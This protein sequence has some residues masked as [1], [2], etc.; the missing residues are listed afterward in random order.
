MLRDG[1]DWMQKEIAGWG[2]KGILGSASTVS[3]MYDNK[4]GRGGHITR[5][6]LLWIVAKAMFQNDNPPV[7]PSSSY[8]VT[9]LFHTDPEPTAGLTQWRLQLRYL[10]LHAH[11]HPQLAAG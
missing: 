4:G 3:A 6:F 1:I 5:A 7:L 8:I 10:R 9:H 11:R 2:L